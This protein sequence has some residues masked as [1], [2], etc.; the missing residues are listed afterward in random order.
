MQ[1]GIGEKRDKDKNTDEDLNIE[2]LR[3]RFSKQRIEESS[4]SGKASTKS[5]M[6]RRKNARTPAASSSSSESV[7]S[8]ESDEDDGWDKEWMQLLPNVRIE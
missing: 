1:V 8:S 7:A 6:A 5:M 4:S 2:H 3:P